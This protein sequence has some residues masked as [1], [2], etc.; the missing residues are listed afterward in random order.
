MLLEVYHGGLHLKLTKFSGLKAP[1]GR[2]VKC[3]YLCYIR[4]DVVVCYN[5]LFCV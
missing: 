3:T 4:L 1:G 5:I 2:V